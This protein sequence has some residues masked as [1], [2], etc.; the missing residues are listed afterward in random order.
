MRRITI[1]VDLEG[2]SMTL[3]DSGANG[4]LGPGEASGVWFTVRNRAIHPVDSAYA[5]SARLLSNDA[6]VEVLESGLP[7]PS[8]ARGSS[9]DN[10]ATPFHVR[11]SNTIALGTHVP[12]RLELTFT[13]AGHTYTQPV[14][15]EIVIGTNRAPV[16]RSPAPAC[17]SSL[18][19]APNPAR[20]HAGFNT[21]LVAA[22][23]RLSIFSPDGSRLATTNVS[24]P[25]TWNCSNVPAGVYFCRLTAASKTVTTSVRVVH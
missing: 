4:Q 21:G 20:S 19:A 5:I 16:T 12:L 15:F 23:G 14:D 6:G 8:A 17:S 10:H 25:Y 13:D 22:A 3:E 7:F 18:T 9:V 24:G 2:V 1:R 11:A